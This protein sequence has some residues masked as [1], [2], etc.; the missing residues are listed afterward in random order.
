MQRHVA[1]ELARARV[2]R[3]RRGGK[4]RET[5]VRE[6]VDAL[7]RTLARTG[8][9]AKFEAHIDSTLMVALDRMPRSVLPS[10]TTAP[11]FP[12]AASG[13]S[14]SVVVGSTKPAARVSAWRSF[15]T[16]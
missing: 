16:C 8:I 4:P 13:W 2:Q 5:P 11:G 7:V 10:K 15:K 3:V 12:K 6:V 1:R 14:D 9:E